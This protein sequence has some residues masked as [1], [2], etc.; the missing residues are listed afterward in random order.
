M[1]GFRDRDFIQTTEGFFF[2]VVGA[3]HPPDRVISYIKY[4]PSDTGI[5]G[6]NTERFSRIL[7]KYTMTNLLQTFNYLETNHPHYLFQ[8]PAD[9]ITVTAVPHTNIK[10]HFKP[11]QKL[12]KLRQT[13]QLD[14]LQQKLIR[15]TRFLAKT[16]G[17]PEES[18]GVTGSLL[19]GIHQPKFSDIDVTVYGR[20]DSWRLHRALNENRNS[21]APMKRLEG[22]T[23]QEW[24]I[25]KAQC[26]PLSPVDAL[27]IYERKWNLGVFEDKWVSIH[28]VKLE[29]EAKETYGET[30]YWSCGQVTI[31]AVVCDNTDCLFLPST[32]KIEDVEVLEGPQHERITEVVA[33][34]SLYDSLAENGET[35]QAK[36]KLERVTEKGNNR[37]RY[38]VLV[39][40]PEGKDREYV[41]RVG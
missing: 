24:C 8:S 36:G 26:Y 5:W 41:K 3:V 14:S 7:Q 4:V 23:L 22:K 6:K 39:G 32:Y 15:F 9:N 21:E 27:K 29:N 1:R 10:T 12:A 11:E 30:S 20:K 40:S 17:V 19:L 25:R 31:R 16:S 18:F 37:E 28:P 33:Y 38:R 34:E 35:I 13:P 2:C